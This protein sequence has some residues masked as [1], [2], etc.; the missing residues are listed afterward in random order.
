MNRFLVQDTSRGFAERSVILDVG[1]VSLTAAI[2][3][4]LD[5]ERS[6]RL[7]QPSFLLGGSA[8]S[9]RPE[10]G[11]RPHDGGARIRP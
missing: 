4:A 7:D 2:L 6:V 10:Q 9:P 11:A 8:R 5:A 3:P 1:L